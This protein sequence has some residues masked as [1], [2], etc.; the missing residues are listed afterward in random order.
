MGSPIGTGR[1]RP[2]WHGAAVAWGLGIGLG[3][4]T[5]WQAVERYH[6]LRTGWSWD[7]AYYNQWF[8]ALLFGDGMLSV[9]P[10]SAYA[11]EGPSVW[12]MNYLAPVRFLIAPIY[13]V[14]PGPI[15]L[16]VLHNL[17]LWL[18]V[19][20]AYHLAR[21][22]S[23]SPRI[24]LT[25]TLLV[26]FTPLLWPLAWN[27]FREL[28][29]GLPFVLWGVQGWRSR[30]TRVAAL[31]VIGML[32]C[33]QEF[34][35]VVASLA[36]VRGREVEDV[37]RRFA[38]SWTALMIGMSWF[39]FGF[40]GYL[41]FMVG[42]GAPSAFLAQ[43]G[44]PRAPLGQLAG[45]SA[46]FLLIGMGPW[47]VVMLLAPRVAA[48]TVPWLWSLAGGKWAL[49][50]IGTTEWHHV[51]YTVP[52]V[53]LSLAAGVIGLCRLMTW[54]DARGR[55]DLMAVA[56]VAM[57]AGLIGANLE[58]QRR[59]AKIPD[60]VAREDVAVFWR[61][62]TEVTPG[63]GVLAHYSLCGP[64]SSRRLLYSYVLDIN[65]PRGY[66][67]LDRRIRWVFLTKGGP[68]TD[69]LV[70][71]GFWVVHESPGMKILRRGSP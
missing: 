49:R 1:E 20:A 59:F 61:Y 31:G 41:R 3:L 13:R 25:A 16:L 34:A 9:Q 23:R 57:L 68:P 42:E 14:A 33:R 37:G 40:F 11:T 51:R 30:S 43:F 65:R 35:V 5:S 55:R 48:L 63:D 53:A 45:T 32:A 21:S 60:P 67:Y 27:D 71:Q 64:L 62:S 18:V 19:P 15:T 10:I 26:P 54:L 50:L 6:A 22:E 36:I 24:A 66:P 38:W 8:W 47:A 17:A 56:W 2:P 28:Q 12:K 4:F 7:L 29:M 69:V 70:E 39:L 58:L 46:D 44:G 52:I